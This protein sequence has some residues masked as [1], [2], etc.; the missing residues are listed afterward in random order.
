VHN[1]SVG[2]NPTGMCHRQG[3]RGDRRRF[4]R[5]EEAV[6][7]AAPQHSAVQQK[8]NIGAGRGGGDTNHVPN[9]QVDQHS[10]VSWSG[11]T[12]IAIV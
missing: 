1:R 5:V 4:K 11:R 8:L 3:T 7:S 10:L 9:G 2:L 6:A 12:G